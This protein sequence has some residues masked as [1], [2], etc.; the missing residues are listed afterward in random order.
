MQQRATVTNAFR[1][2]DRELEWL[3][4][5]LYEVGKR[6]QVKLSKQEVARFGLDIVL[7]DYQARGDASLLSELARR[8][9]R[10]GPAEE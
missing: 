3:T 9:K 7:A 8:R 6:H 5:T 4:D 10:Q 2:T 1:Y